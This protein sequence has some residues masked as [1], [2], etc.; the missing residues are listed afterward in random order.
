MNGRLGNFGWD[1]QYL[2]MARH[3]G[4]EVLT[5]EAFGPRDASGNCAIQFTVR[6][7]PSSRLL[8]PPEQS[9]I[10]EGNKDTDLQY[11]RMLGPVAGAQPHVLFT[12]LPGDQKFHALRSTY[13]Q[14]QGQA[15][16]EIANEVRRQHDT[17]VSA[18]DTRSQLGLIGKLL[19]LIQDS[20]SPAHIDRRPGSGWCVAYVRN[21][22][23]SQW[24][25]AVQARRIFGTN[26]HGVPI[27]LRDHID[28]GGRR[29]AEAVR[30]TEAS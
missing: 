6:G 11:L 21:Y 5:R 8:T 14:P 20:F 29:R 19:H 12:L 3:E 4:H 18:R 2:P 16:T 27:D 13:L 1:T 7:A 24:H 26:E 10:I 25:P 17:I 9:L 22:G 28:D 15:L 30:A 23:P